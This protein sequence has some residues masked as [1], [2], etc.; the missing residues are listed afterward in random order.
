M[1]IP[2]W[3]KGRID[4][5]N[6]LPAS[7]VHIWRFDLDQPPGSEASSLGIRERQRLADIRRPQAARRYLNTRLQLRGILASYLAVPPATLK[8]IIQPGGKPELANGSLQFN[9]SHSQGLGLLAVSTQD[10]VGVDLEKIR[11]IKYPSRIVRRM[12]SSETFKQWSAMDGEDRQLLFFQQWTAMEA[13]QKTL[14]LGI[15]SPP[16]APDTLHC[17]HFTAADGFVAAL[18]STSSHA[19]PALQ[20][21]NSPSTAYDAG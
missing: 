8:F 2:H 14:G 5:I 10:P 6:T 20:F 15:F 16:V 4:R 12:F 1:Y 19:A 17:R 9:L 7:E 11:D 21:F 13:R 18:A 3:Q